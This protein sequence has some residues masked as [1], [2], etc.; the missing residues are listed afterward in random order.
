MELIFSLFLVYMIIIIY[1][2]YLINQ[3]YRKHN[4]KP[5]IKFLTE[6][7]KHLKEKESETDNIEEKKLISKVILFSRLTRYMNLAIILAVV[8]ATIFFKVKSLFA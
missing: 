3:L 4:F 7:L 1:R 2:T 5:G 8:F 6:S